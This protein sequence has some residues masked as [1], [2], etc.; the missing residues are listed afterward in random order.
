[1][2][3]TILI[4]IAIIAVIFVISAVVAL[5]VSHSTPALSDNRVA[6]IALEGTIEMSSPEGG[7]F[8]SQ[9]VTPQEFKSK[10]DRA[11]ADDSVKAIVI[12]INS[13]G[14]SVVASEEIARQIKKAREKKPVVAWLGEIAT[15]GGYF[16]ASAC[17]YIVADPA[18]ITGSIGVISIFPEYSRLFQKLGINMTVIKAGRYKDFSTG[19]RPLTQE[20]R[21]MMEEIINDTY[22]LFISEVAENRNLSKEYVRSIAEGRIYSGRKAVELGLANEVGSFEDAVNKAAELGG[23]KGKPEIVTYEKPNLLREILWGSMESLGRGIGRA[24][25]ENSQRLNW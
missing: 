19:F 16:V 12:Y 11:L 8:S 25:V 18:T 17:D 10:L 20:E 14:G 21:E 6:V 9:G 7:F 2:K 3:K 4:G 13:P 1:M 22:D 23:I 15:S 5:L 24:L